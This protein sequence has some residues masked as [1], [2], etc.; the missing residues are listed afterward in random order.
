[1]T[2]ERPRDFDTT[3]VTRIKTLHTIRRG[4][5]L[6]LDAIEVLH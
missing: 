3:A 4:P 5:K 2:S 1:V 6:L